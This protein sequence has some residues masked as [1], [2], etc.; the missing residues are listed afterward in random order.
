MNINESLKRFR[1]K[2]KLTQD[3]VAKVLGTSKQAYYRY[4]KDVTP[5]AEIIKK[6]ALAF[7]VSA[8]YLL[9]I[10]DIPNNNPN[11][12]ILR[13]IDKFNLNI[14]Q[15][16]ACISTDEESAKIGARNY[17]T[18]GLPPEPPTEVEKK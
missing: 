3:D 10:T 2:F 12:E 17:L 15:I 7:G 5:S 8:D 1:Q 6:I 14:A 18:G 13:A 16:T 4:E 9:G 11:A